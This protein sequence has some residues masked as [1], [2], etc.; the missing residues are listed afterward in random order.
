MDD[1][2]SS[3]DNTNTANCIVNVKYKAY[4]RKFYQRDVFL[5]FKSF[6]S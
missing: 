4:L 5:C 1:G 3:D 2:G 6:L